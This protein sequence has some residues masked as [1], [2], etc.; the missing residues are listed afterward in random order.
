MII[1]NAANFLAAGFLGYVLGRFGDNYLNIWM[2][3][4]KWVPHHWIYGLLLMI[5][6]FLF[7]NNNLELWTISF[8]LGLFISDLKDF[9]KMKIFAPDGKTKENRKFWHID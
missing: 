1:L 9:W 2:G 4:P 6:G 3:D 7:F 8:G 5:I